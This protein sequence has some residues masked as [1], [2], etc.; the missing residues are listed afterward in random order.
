MINFEIGQKSH[1]SRI[2]KIQIDVTIYSEVID[3]KTLVGGLVK[4]GKYSMRHLLDHGS[5]ILNLD[6]VIFNH[7]KVIARPA[8]FTKS[9]R[10]L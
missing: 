6:Q 9:G 5:A 4:V 10:N 8:S 2:D 1:Y 3:A 7:P